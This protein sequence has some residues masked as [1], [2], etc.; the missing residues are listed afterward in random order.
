MEIKNSHR[1]TLCARKTKRTIHGTAS[2]PNLKFDVS[3][4]VF[5]SQPSCGV[6]QCFSF[7][8]KLSITHCP[9]HIDLISFH[10]GSISPWKLAHSLM[11]EIWNHLLFAAM[12]DG[13]RSNLP[14]YLGSK[15]KQLWT[16][17]WNTVFMNKATF[18]TFFS[19]ISSIAVDERSGVRNRLQIYDSSNMAI[20]LQ[21]P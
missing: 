3:T 16:K 21:T 2:I 15:R 11:G 8:Y 20:C 14:Y 17:Q 19:R 12:T 7:S 4:R 5:S 10:V 9:S 1:K 6:Q 13:R 18:Y